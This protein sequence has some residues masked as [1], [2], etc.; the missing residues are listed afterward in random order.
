MLSQGHLKALKVLGVG[1]AWCKGKQIL[2]QV[3]DWIR[4]GTMAEVEE[5]R[6]SVMSTPV[7]GK[8]VILTQ[9]KLVPSTLTWLL[10]IV[11]SKYLLRIESEG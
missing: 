8:G 11:M 7:N 9:I 6:A 1:A 4:E 3:M 10:Q 5:R 2:Q